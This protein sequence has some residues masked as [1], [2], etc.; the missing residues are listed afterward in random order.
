MDDPDEYAIP[1][2]DFI[3]A[4]APRN[5]RGRNSGRGYGGEYG[6]DRSRGR[7]HGYQGPDRLPPRILRQLNMN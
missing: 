1:P 6:R 4:P 7:A 3:P 5:D 2:E